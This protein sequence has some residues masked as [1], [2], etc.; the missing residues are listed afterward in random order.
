MHIHVHIKMVSVFVH[1]LNNNSHLKY[2]F[3]AIHQEVPK[4][5]KKTI[6]IYK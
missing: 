3:D 5:K 4:N 2:N 1:T 6:L